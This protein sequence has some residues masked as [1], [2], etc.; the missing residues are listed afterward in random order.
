MKAIIIFKFVYVHNNTKYYKI[1]STDGGQHSFTPFILCQ[2][3]IDTE[4]KRRKLKISD[5]SQFV[6]VTKYQLY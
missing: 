4:V 1:Q 2:R 5:Y 6:A 3:N